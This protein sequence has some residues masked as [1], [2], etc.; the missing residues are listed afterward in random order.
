VVNFD[1][2]SLPDDYVHRVGRTARAE[3]IGDALTLVS[4]DEEADLRT[5]ERAVGS[6]IARVRLPGFDY[7]RKAAERFEV[8]LA[9]RIAAIRARKA[10]DRARARVNAERRRP[11]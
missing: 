4:P 10:E 9:E 6:R 2:P 1:V 8:P 5:I 3:A 11:C 7:A